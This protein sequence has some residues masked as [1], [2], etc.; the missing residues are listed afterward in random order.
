MFTRAHVTHVAEGHAGGATTTAD[1]KENVQD[2]RHDIS[3][4]AASV[5]RLASESPEIA[6]QKLETR[7]RREPLKAMAWAAGAGF[8]LALILRR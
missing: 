2:I 3:E 6:Q 4:L 8:I 1:V 7:I 5:R